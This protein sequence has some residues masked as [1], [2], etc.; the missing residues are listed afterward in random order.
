VS[1]DGSRFFAPFH[2][3]GWSPEYL[4]S[5]AY[6]GR[7]G[8]YRVRIA[9]DVA[10]WRPGLDGAHERDFVLRFLLRTQDVQHVAR[11]LYHRRESAPTALSPAALAHERDALASYL[12]ASGESFTIEAG[13]KGDEVRFLP[14]GE[15]L[16]SIVIPTANASIQ[17]NGSTEWH[18]DAVVESIAAKTT[19]RNYEIVVVHN[20]NLR[21][22]QLERLQARANVRIVF[23]AAAK[24]NLADKIN[25]GCAHARGEYLV[26]MNDDVRVIT[27][28][29]VEW[30][31]GMAQR[32]GVGAVGAKLLF[33]DGT[34]QHAGVVIIGG[35]PGHA[36]YQWPGR[37]E[38]YRAQASVAR[39]CVAVTGACMMT[40]KALYDAMGGFASK[41]RMN[42]N[43]V[44]YCLRLAEMGYRSVYVPQAVLHHYEGVSREGGRSTEVRELETFLAD[45]GEKFRHD[46]YYNPNLSQRTAYAT[47]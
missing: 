36:F 16:V 37:S 11:V 32:K 41:Y 44:D 18:L 27:P 45:W 26:L 34:I 8:V 33:P 47:V 5:L 12:E 28:E 31:L 10:G 24:F 35:C 25:L 6:T 14:R 3:P 17:L 7:L 9:R 23:Y 29:W 46:P 2:K 43:D 39:N 42:Y 4:H 22:D 19:W 40:R 1:A 38:G 15:P 13:S 21:S 20:G 30:M